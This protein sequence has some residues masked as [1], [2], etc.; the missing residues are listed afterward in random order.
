MANLA[1]LD[2]ERMR[3]KPVTIQSEPPNGLIKPELENGY[4]RLVHE[5]LI[6]L[7]GYP[8]PGSELRAVL[9]LFRFSYG[10]H[11]TEAELSLA[12]ICRF[13]H[14]TKPNAARTMRGLVDKNVVFKIDNGGVTVYKFNKYYYQWKPL[15]KSTKPK[16]KQ[17]ESVINFDKPS[18]KD[19]KN[20]LKPIETD[21]ADPDPV[22]DATE[23]P[24][25]P[26]A[27]ESEVTM[28][29]MNEYPDDFQP[30]TKEQFAELRHKLKENRRQAAER[31]RYSKRNRSK[32]GLY[33]ADSI[34]FDFG[35]NRDPGGP[36]D[37][38]GGG[39]VQTVGKKRPDTGD[40]LD[41]DL[42]P[43]LGNDSRHSGKT[44]PIQGSKSDPGRPS[45]QG[46]NKP[47]FRGEPGSPLARDLGHADQGDDA[48]LRVESEAD[49]PGGRDLDLGDLRSK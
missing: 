22:G 7:A 1:Y 34:S 27:T 10:F 8:L 49:F 32:R 2:A 19:N 39:V 33:N 6:A 9:L 16:Q 24:P 41:G 13:L 47:L 25:D 45:N 48:R 29:N 11:S 35:Y 4:T 30:I 46:G 36:G 31:E 17:I 44:G 15:Q 14:M 5:I 18:F 43:R 3:D 20:K 38:Q 28:G 21:N 42:D 23:S 26:T 12:K 37:D 40:D